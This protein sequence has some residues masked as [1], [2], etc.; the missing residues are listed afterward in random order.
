M[1]GKLLDTAIDIATR[2]V[3]DTVDVVDGLTEG[4]FRHLAAMRLSTDVVA[5][6]TI[7]EIIELLEEIE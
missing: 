7:S 2:P 4:E 3:V 6:L 5:G 1:F